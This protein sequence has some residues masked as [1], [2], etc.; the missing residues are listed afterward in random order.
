M[1]FSYEAIDKDGAT[2]K[3]EFQGVSKKEVIDHLEK[4]GLTPISIQTLKEKEGTGLSFSLHLFEKFTALDR[5]FLVRNLSAMIRAGM[6]LSETLDILLADSTK[7]LMRAILSR[8]QLNLQSGQPLSATFSAYKRFFPSVFIGMLK[9]GEASG[10]LSKVLDE[11]GRFMIRDY[12]LVRKVRSAL[13]Y[14]IMLL[15]G[16]VGVVILLLVFVLPRLSKVFEQSGVELPFITKLIMS[17]SKALSFNPFLDLIIIGGFVWF[18]TYFK[19]TDIGQR[20][21]LWVTF[22]LPVAK[23]L[24][25]KVALV[26]FSRTLGS[27][28][29]SG[30][31]FIEALELTADSVGNEYYRKAILGSVE[32]V[33]NGISFSKTFSDHLDIFPRSLISLIA[34]GEKTGTMDNILKTFADFYDEEVDDTLKDLTTFLEPVLLMAM[35]LIIGA[36]ALSILLPI[37]QLVGSFR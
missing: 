21:F 1:I 14:P 16:S 6:N 17:I 30:I 18:F 3:G 24:S 7:R 36:I 20:F 11:L 32:Q 10:Q 31:S 19:K 29:S 33:K 34:V 15:I 25:K 9:A 27:L 5:I 37:Y 23:E 2:E 35:G 26:K 4:K 22:R 13:M 12:S 28:I 8:A